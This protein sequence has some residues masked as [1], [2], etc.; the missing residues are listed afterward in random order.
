LQMAIATSSRW[1]AATSHGGRES[2]MSADRPYVLIA[3]GMLPALNA[4]WGERG[5]STGAELS[6]RSSL[7]SPPP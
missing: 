7:H 6:L 2:A 1:I 3:A 5:S 4:F